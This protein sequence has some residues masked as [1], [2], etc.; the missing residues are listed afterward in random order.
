MGPLPITAYTLVNA[1]GDDTE[2]VI[3]ALEHG[4]TG[5]GRHAFATSLPTV[6]GA[7]GQLDT[8]PAALAAYDTR[9]AR[10]AWH[11]I[12]GLVVAAS[13]ATTRWGST[14][15]GLVIGT[16]TGGI[17]ATEAA[18]RR[19]REDGSWPA[20]F[21]LAR[22]HAMQATVEV[23]RAATGA[24]GPG[25]VVSTACSS[26]AKA[27]ASAQRMI[28]ADL[29]DAVIVGG[30]DSLCDTTLRGFAGLELT[31]ERACRPFASD[32]DGI[33][34]GEGAAFALVERR[35]HALAN[36]VAVGESCD[37]Y[38]P[39]APHPEGEGARAAIEAALRCAGISASQVGVVNA[40]AT[41]TKLN[42]A[43]EAK[44]LAA[45]F[46]G[47]PW[48]VATKGY[49]G[50]MLGAAGAT[51]VL[52]CVVALERGWI[53]A[54]LGADPLEPGLGIRVATQRVAIETDYAL[55][56][57]FAFGGSNAAVLVGGAS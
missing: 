30:V 50:H 8:L 17:G 25:Y 36:L 1:L 13:R 11:G 38:H 4:D 27:F 56:T 28:H 48:V 34:I 14:R 12:G 3:T 31:S 32:R 15:V 24:R 22:K 57:S 47:A 46:G 9:Q 26:S 39:S 33:S 54:S 55:S 35:G 7:I 16:S 10:I 20:D 29:V 18:W 43:S 2:A 37:A 53:P 41:G 51:E 52:F 5:L 44:A 19:Y 42:D 49:T 45:V 23:V 40:H 21:D 6:V